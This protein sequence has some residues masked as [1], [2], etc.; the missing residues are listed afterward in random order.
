MYYTVYRTINKINQKEYVGFHKIHDI[1]N[2]VCQKSEDGSIY[3]DGYLGS[4]KLMKSALEKYGPL[5][6]CQE[7]LLLSHD[8][9]E[10]EEYE[11][12]IVNV[13]WVKNE[14][15][16]NLSIGG[17][18]CILFG[19]D[20]GFFG[21]KHSPET[22]SKIQDTRN[23]TLKESPFNFAE[24]MHVDTNETFYNTK[25]ACDSF[26]V[27]FERFN[28]AKLVYENKLIFKSKYLQ[29]KSLDFYHERVLFLS[30]TQERKKKKSE[31]TSKRFKGI[32]K[33][34]ESNIKRGK[35]IS[36]WIN[37]NPNKHKEKMNKIN[38][39]PEKIKKTAE[40]HLGMKRSKSTRENISNSLKGKTSK[41]KD[42]IFIF[43]INTNE[44]KMIEKDSNVPNGWSKGYGKK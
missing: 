7:L 40:K 16:Y 1:E 42:K 32:A 37:E 11:K 12:D 39:N 29:T 38:K 14:D 28:V 21:K 43:N 17:N 2:I 33:T 41:N 31:D 10:A 15:N 20:N 6:M 3:R 27:K 30:E 23:Q 34:K 9:K 36:K 5:N 4:G 24:C 25:D 44:R 26:N 22:I 18:V 13:E 8:K 19:E 35:S